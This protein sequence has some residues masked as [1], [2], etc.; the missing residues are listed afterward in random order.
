MLGG[1]IKFQFMKKNS[2]ILAEKVYELVS[3]IPEGK[4]LRYG[5]IARAV[6]THPRVVGRIL[7]NNPYSSEKVPCH[8]VVNSQ[9]KCAQT[10]AFGG[11]DAQLKLLRNEGVVFNKD[12][13]DLANSL[14]RPRV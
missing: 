9:G 6:E 5:D 8:R 10:Y 2:H 12:R 11:L 1:V 7:H 14:W 4:V 3:R 13:V